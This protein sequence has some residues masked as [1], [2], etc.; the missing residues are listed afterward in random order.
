MQHSLL[1]ADKYNADQ[2]KIIAAVKPIIS[3]TSDGLRANLED[4]L[5]SNKQFGIKGYLLSHLQGQLATIMLTGHLAGMRRA[6]LSLRQKPKSLWLSNDNAT[7]ELSVFS[8]V[9]KYL[10]NKVSL[11]LNSLQKQYDTLALKVLSSAS[12][13]INN[14]LA[15]T[16]N[17][18]ISGGAHVREAKQILGAKFDQLGLKPASKSQLETI[19]RT[20][21][22]IAFSAG[23]YRAERG[24][25]HIEKELWGYKYV[26]AGDDRVRPTHDALE[27]VT[28]PKDHPFWTMFYPPNGWNC[29]CQAIPLFEPVELVPPPLGLNGQ[30][31]MPDKGFVWRAGDIF[32]PILAS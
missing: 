3:W 32:N 16:V 24:T 18:L 11:D 1:L 9:L 2:D 31:L 29:R 22:Q 10:T 26:T 19:F 30:P 13:N 5:R 25:P 15:K 7:L 17:E 21:T 12:D 14:E 27:G 28:L 8:N 4:M 20:Q 6:V 23:K